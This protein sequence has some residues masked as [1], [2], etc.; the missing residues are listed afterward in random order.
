MMTVD[1][2]IKQR[3]GQIRELL[4][5]SCLKEAL[6]QIRIQMSGLSDWS[7]TSVFEDIERSYR[8]MLH[9]FSQGSP[10]IHRAEVYRQLVRRTLLLNDDILQARLQPKSM[11]LYYQHMRTRML[12]HN[13]IDGL[14][15]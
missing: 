11:L 15:A 12:R 7:I 13:T 14:R 8:Y 4:L 9:Y 2:E 10:D 1:D 5:K 3:A 6:E